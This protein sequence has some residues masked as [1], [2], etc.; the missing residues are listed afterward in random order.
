MKT[1]A[2]QLPAEA[3]R[4]LS[5]RSSVETARAARERGIVAEVLGATVWRWLSADA[6][7]P[8]RYRS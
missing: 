2:C 6:I 5:R 3:E 1:L 7:R 8:F 4:P